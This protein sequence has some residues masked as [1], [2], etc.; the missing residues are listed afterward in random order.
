VRYLEAHQGRAR[1]LVATLNAGE[2]EPFILST[3]KPVMDLGGFMGGDH[4]LSV[5]QLAALVAKGT[6]RYFLLPARGSD[7]FANLPSRT[8][9]LL[10]RRGG[11]GGRFR[12]GF[13]GAA[14]AGLEQWVSSHCRVVPPTAYGVATAPSSIGGLGFGGGQ[15]LY[16]CGGRTG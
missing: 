4:I 2:A 11:L 7:R 5:H 8:R 16:D 12:G 1:F 9:S 15:Q 14:N 6:I 13:G 3:G 10:E